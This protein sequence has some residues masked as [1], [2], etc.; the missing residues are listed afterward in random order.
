MHSAKEV[1]LP[2]VVDASEVRREPSQAVTAFRLIHLHSMLRTA[3]KPLNSCHPGSEPAST[4][5]S[6]TLSLPG[7]DSSCSCQ[8]KTRK[9]PSF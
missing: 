5:L 4:K 7:L 8:R 9:S 6:S 2:R 1:S 3:P